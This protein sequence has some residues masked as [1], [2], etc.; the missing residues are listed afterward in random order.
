MLIFVCFKWKRSAEGFQLPGVCSY[1]AKHVNVLRN[2]LERNV[3]LEHRLICV[4]DDPDGIDERIETVTLWDKCKS[5]GGC[6]N[7]LWVFS[8]EARELFGDRFVCIDL[9]CVITGDCTEL[10]SRKED[11]V[12]NSYNPAEVAPIDQHYNG[13]LFMV[14]AGARKELW[15]DFDP[16]TTP[17]TVQADTNTIGTDQAW[18]RHKLGKDEARF[19]NADGVYE[20]RQIGNNLTPNVKIVF[21]SGKRD[22]S[23]QSYRWIARHWL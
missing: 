21:F 19:T 14:T 16:L 9:D 8:E 1:T 17:A 3:Q 12:I 2:M 5:L 13:S 20:A 4:T 18:I 23:Q 15:D 11:F 7:R 22:P 10:F 6:Y